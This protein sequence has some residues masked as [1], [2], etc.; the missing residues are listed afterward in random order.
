MIKNYLSRHSS[1]GGVVPTQHSTSGSLYHSETN[2]ETTTT[3]TTSTTAQLLT[4]VCIVLCIVVAFM[5]WQRL[6]AAPAQQTNNA[7][8]AYSSKIAGLN[9][10]ELDGTPAQ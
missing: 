6:R 9:F 2:S 4:V 3:A 10:E 1:S 7:P 5:V 8:D